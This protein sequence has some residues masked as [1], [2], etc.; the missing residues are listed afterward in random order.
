MRGVTPRREH[1]CDAL[2]EGTRAASLL[3]VVDVIR[4]STAGAPVHGGSAI[5]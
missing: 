2:E 4:L 3:V 1:T 5:Y